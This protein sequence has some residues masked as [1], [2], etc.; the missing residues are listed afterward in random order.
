M[1]FARGCLCY[2][3]APQWSQ[4]GYVRSHCGLQGLPIVGRERLAKLEKTLG[5]ETNGDILSTQGAAASQGGSRNKTCWDVAGDT[6]AHVACY[7]D[8]VTE[9]DMFTMD[10]TAPFVVR[11]ARRSKEAIKPGVFHTL[12]DGFKQQFSTWA[13]RKGER[14]GGPEAQRFPECCHCVQEARQLHPGLSARQR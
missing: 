10:L 6:C 8:P 5:Q 9:H 13:K 1:R 14:R 2:N 7:I 3:R 11:G 12:I 4:E